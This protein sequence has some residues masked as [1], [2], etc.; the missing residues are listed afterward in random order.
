MNMVDLNIQQAEVVAF[1]KQGHNTLITGQAGVGK[2]EVVR[3]II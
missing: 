2:S 3:Y 1:V